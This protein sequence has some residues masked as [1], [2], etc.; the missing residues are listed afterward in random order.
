MTFLKNFVNVLSVASISFILL[1]AV[2]FMIVYFNLMDGR[3]KSKAGIGFIVFGAICVVAGL[4]VRPLLYL[5]VAYFLVL[6][7]L[8]SLGGRLWDGKVGKWMLIFG[9]GRVR[10]LAARSELLSHRRE[11]GQRARS[12]R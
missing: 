4:F 12:P 9:V 11:A 7:G 8:A 10:A 5:G 6:W 1:S 2:F 3:L